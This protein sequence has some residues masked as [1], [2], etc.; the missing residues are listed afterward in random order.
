MVLTR[1]YSCAM[2]GGVSDHLMCLIKACYFSS[3]IKF[4]ILYSLY[5]GKKINIM[6]FTVLVKSFTLP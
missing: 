3:Y 4:N 5:M 6:V 2:I 1:I